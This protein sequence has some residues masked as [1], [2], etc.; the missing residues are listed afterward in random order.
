MEYGNTDSGFP[1][2]GEAA[3]SGGA[4]RAL[5][6]PRDRF[7]S[8]PVRLCEWWNHLTTSLMLLLQHVRTLT[9][10]RDRSRDNHQGAGPNPGRMLTQ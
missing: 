1:L 4:A 6:H 3:A 8:V 2:G 7:G 9:R 5:T 10:G